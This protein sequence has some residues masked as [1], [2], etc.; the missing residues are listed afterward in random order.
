MKTYKSILAVSLVM[1]V[2]IYSCNNPVKT[3]SNP[4]TD[5]KSK[6]KEDKG[7]TGKWKEVNGGYTFT[8]EAREDGK[9]Y[10]LFKDSTDAKNTFPCLITKTKGRNEKDELVEKLSILPKDENGKTI[11]SLFYSPQ[12]DKITSESFKRVYYSRR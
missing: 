4:V 11:I 12:E 2:G 8:L 9:V 10:F 6:P 3:N 5:V 1:T 7:Y